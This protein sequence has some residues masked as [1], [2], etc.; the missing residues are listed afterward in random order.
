MQVTFLEKHSERAYALLRIFA[1]LLFMAHGVQKLLSFP[2]PFPM[3]LNP[4]STA[5]GCIELVAGA[6]IAIGLFTRPAA[7][8]ASG[9]C[10]VGYFMVHAPSGFFPIVNGG[11]QIALYSVLFLFVATKGAGVWSIEAA[12]RKS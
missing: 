3:P 5:A 8:V 9:M 7:F 1:G 6:L 10:A 11:E 12:T 2:V 4:M